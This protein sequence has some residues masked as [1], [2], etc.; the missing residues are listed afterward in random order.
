MK[1]RLLSYYEIEQRFMDL[2]VEIAQSPMDEETVIEKGSLLAFALGVCLSQMKAPDSPS[3]PGKNEHIDVLEK[4][5]EAI[6]YR[7]NTCAVEEIVTQINIA[8]SMF[9]LQ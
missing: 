7:I 4:A 3:Y 2:L 1:A 6:T 9:D 5:S 8:S